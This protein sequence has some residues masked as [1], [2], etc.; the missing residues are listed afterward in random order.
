MFRNAVEAEWRACLVPCFL[1]LLDFFPVRPDFAHIFDFRRA[2][3]MRV[4]ADEFLHEQAA[5]FSKSNAPRSFASWQ[6]KTT[7]INKSPSSSAISWSSP[8]SIASINS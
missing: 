6:W 1:R 5:D 2:K 8:A 7:C 3:D 4:P